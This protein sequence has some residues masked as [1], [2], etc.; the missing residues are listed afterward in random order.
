MRRV[1][2]WSLI[3]LG[4]AGVILPVLPGVVF[5]VL[6][7]ALLGP[8]HPLLRRCAFTLRLVL[9]RWSRAR[10]PLVARLG[11]QVRLRHRTMRL[12]MREQ[13]ARVQRGEYHRRHYLAWAALL[14]LGMLGYAGAA[15]AIRMGMLHLAQL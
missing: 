10:R 11:W 4:V 7:V 5:F 6:G 3:A 12:A 14:V 13:T 2:G 15:F 9:R 1:G 8:R